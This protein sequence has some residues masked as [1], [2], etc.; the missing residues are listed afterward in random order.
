MV[1]ILQ[2][3]DGS[4]IAA[5]DKPGHIRI[6]PL[7]DAVPSEVVDPL[8]LAQVAVFAVLAGQRAWIY[9]SEAWV[10]DGV[11]RRTAQVRV[12]D[13]TFD[14]PKNE[15]DLEGDG[16]GDRPIRVTVTEGSGKT[17]PD[18]DFGGGHFMECG[19]I[20]ETTVAEYASGVMVDLE[21]H[22]LLT[23]TDERRAVRA[24]LMN[25]LVSEP[26]LESGG[27]AVLV[28][29]NGLERVHVG[30]TLESL[31]SPDT[32]QDAQENLR[33]V[34]AYVTAEVPLIRLTARPPKMDPRTAASVE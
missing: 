14:W 21:V 4:T 12:A 7:D 15:A 20:D 16:D 9:D 30:L 13:V 34:T 17:R 5:P 24:M 22:C 27:R 10:R 2:N 32:P 1:E 8:F 26:L 23:H 18:D 29:I 6:P 19:I 25:A 3:P 11:R 28:P 33:L 31:A